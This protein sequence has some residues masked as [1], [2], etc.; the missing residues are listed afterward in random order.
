MRKTVLYIFFFFIYMAPASLSAQEEF[1]EPSSRS[2]TK[3]SFK[4]LTGGVILVNA[5]IQN[6]PDTLNFIFDTGSG[7]ISLDSQTAAYLKLPQ[8]VSDRTIRGIAGIRTVNFINNLTLHLPGLSVD[9][10]NFHVNNYEILTS[11]YGEKIDGIIGYSVLKRFIIKVN[12][13]SSQIEFFTKGTMRYPKGGYLLT[14]QINA[15]P[16]QAARVKDELVI[17]T[18]FLYDM[19]AGLCLMLSQ[20]FVQDSAL[21]SKKRKLYAKEAEGVGGKVDMKVTVIKEF[22]MGPYRFRNVPTYVFDDVYNVTAYPQLGGIIGNDLLRRFNCIINYNKSEIHITPNSHFSEQFDYSYGGLE[23]YY[24]DG[25]IVIGDVAEK[26][27]AE[28]VGLK[29]GDI[30][31]SVGNNFTQ[32]LA[33]YKLALQNTGEK[34]RMIINRNG[35]LMQFD[36][37]VLNILKKQ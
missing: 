20:E 9:S 1:I 32:N 21:L 30:V 2:L 27:P 5:R 11:V 7:G 33:Q 15:L 18:R 25:L 19:G 37:K 3:F 10:L 6:F 22:K 8:V 23:L 24:I 28:K 12:F 35:A 29:E 36:F 4:Q 16:I 26:S 14:P 17:S 31:I 34:I 13:D